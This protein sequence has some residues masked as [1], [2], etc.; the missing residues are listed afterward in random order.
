MVITF[1]LVMAAWIFF[2]APTVEAA[3]LHVVYMFR[4][5]LVA[6]GVLIDHVMGMEMARIM[7]LLFAEWCGRRQQ[8]ALEALPQSRTLRWALYYA[9][10]VVILL[11]TGSGTTREFISY[12][13]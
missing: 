10:V 8:H 4:N 6:P 7:A 9:V 13:F 11:H 1:L 12:Q 3:S 5:L 2:R